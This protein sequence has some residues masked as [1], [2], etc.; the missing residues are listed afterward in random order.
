MVGPTP[1]T[2][3]VAMVMGSVACSVS[4]GESDVE[5]LDLF[6]EPVPFLVRFCAVLVDVFEGKSTSL[7]GPEGLIT[8]PEAGCGTTAFVFVETEL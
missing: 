1:Q 8:A 6:R 4:T 5:F 2:T 3:A 7:D